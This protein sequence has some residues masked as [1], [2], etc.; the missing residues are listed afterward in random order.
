MENW[1]AIFREGLAPL[2]SDDALHAL[3]AALEGDDARL[4]QG[5]AAHPWP[6]EAEPSP[7]VEAAC[8]LGFAL[9]QADRLETCAQVEVSFVRL[10]EAI[11]ARMGDP[12][13]TWALT[14][15]WDDPERED[16]VRAWHGEVM[17][18]ISRRQAS[19]TDT[20]GQEPPF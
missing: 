2:L 6:T 20:L 14:H 11:D 7:Y 17:L 3:R 19:G 5:A 4:L 12:L 18:E 1:R 16:A 10:A 13:A 8:P 15:A 9:W